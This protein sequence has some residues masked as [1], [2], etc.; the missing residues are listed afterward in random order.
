MFYC[1][2]ISHHDAPL[3]VREQLSLTHQQQSEWLASQQ[4][5]AVVLATCN[6]LELYAHL[7]DERAMEALWAHLLRLRR[8]VPDAVGPHTRAFTGLE[9]ARHLFRV[10][11]GLESMALGEPQILGQVTQAY[12]LAQEQQAAGAAL[13]LLFRAAIHAAKRAHHETGIDSGS[14]SVSSLGIARAESTH[15]PLAARSVLVIGAGEMAQ[16]ILKGLAQ[17]GVTDVTLLSRTY[18]NARRLAAEWNVRARPITEMKAALVEADVLFTTSSAPF[19][20]LSPEDL[21]P[22]MAERP[23]RDLCIVDLAMPRDVDPAVGQVP[24]VRLHDLDDLQGV[25]EATLAERQAAVPAAEA[26]LEEELAAFWKDYQARAVA[27]TIRQL[28]ERAEAL[29]QA[30]LDRVYHRLPNECADQRALFDQF[31]HR[32]MNKLLHQLTHNLKERAADDD[33]ARVAAVARELFGL[34]DAADVI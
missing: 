27:P 5:E 9:A 23:E 8:V 21:A 22:V 2:S 10:S 15:G 34:E 17:R 11:G 31:S 1:R 29:R 13:A 25:I 6:R 30:E 4:A 19:T 20:I 14:A 3:T 18:E 28:R 7:P 26:I 24:R 32:F 33:A 12:H 16:V